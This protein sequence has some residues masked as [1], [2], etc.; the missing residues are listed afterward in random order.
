MKRVT[1]YLFILVGV[2]FWS[3]SEETVHTVVEDSKSL[4]ESSTTISAKQFTSSDYELGSLS[5]YQF[6]KTINVTG[7]IHIP[8]KNKAIV[9]SQLDGTV[10][11]IKLVEGEWVKKGQALFNITNPGLIELQ[12]NFLLNR[13]EL[14]YNRTDLVRLQEL[15]ADKLT[16]IHKLNEV[17]SSIKKLE[18]KQASLKIRLELYGIDPIAVSNESLLSAVT[19]S[20]PISGYVS[21]IHV[22]NGMFLESSQKA[23]ELTNTTHKQ[24]ELLVLEK[25]MVNIKKGQKVRF[26]LQDNLAKEYT[27][28]VNL[29]NAIADENHT[30][31][32]HCLLDEKS[33]SL[34]PGMF[35]SAKIITDSYQG[36][37]LPQGGIVKI[38]NEH[39][40]LKLLDKKN[41]SLEFEQVKLE[42]GSKDMFFTEVKNTKDTLAQ[43]LTRGAYFLIVD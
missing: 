4:A 24:L 36:Y 3:C 8:Q 30:V 29:I 20:A 27:A 14:A 21:K 23:I 26:S 37:A 28:T 22:I 43:Y 17:K 15:V 38:G 40:G 34:I 33:K 9:S 19:V 13:E 2:S 1:I 5:K 25:D 16:T 18:S 35:V 7:K 12:E 42:L 39:F 10:G 32:I 6:S 31:S 41:G 11:I